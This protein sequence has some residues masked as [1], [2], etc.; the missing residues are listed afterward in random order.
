MFSRVC[1]DCGGP[2]DPRSQRCDG[3][4]RA[5]ERIPAI[6]RLGDKFVFAADGC[7][8]WTRSVNDEGYGQFYMPTGTRRS[9]VHRAHR[10]V[11]EL[12]N[13]PIPDGLHLD[14]LCRVP[15]CVNPAHL[16]PVTARENSHRGMSPTL[17]AHREN[18]CLNGHEF[19][20]EN[21]ILEKSGTKRCR[22]CRNA[23]LQSRRLQVVT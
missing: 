4:N 5:V 8:L 10:F 17:V 18:R 16:E 21:T 14:H 23:Y 20:A 19:T 2:S 13:G 7:W 6:E 15:R 12:I 22:R 3:C 9:K 11:Y 1:I